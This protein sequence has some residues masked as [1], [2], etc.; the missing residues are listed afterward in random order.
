[1]VTAAPTRRYTIDDLA[2]LPDDGKRRELDDG[3]IVEWD[4]PDF[5]HGFFLAVLE[6]IIGLFVSEHRLGAMTGGDQMVRILQSRHSARGADVAF[7]RRGR[8]PTDR[9]AAATVGVPD[10][11]IELI[12]PSD[13]AA[14]VQRKV[15]DWLRT[16]VKLLWYVNPETG[17]TTVYHAGRL[18]YAGPDD[19]LTGEDVLPGFTMRMRDVLD[20]L[21]ELV[22]PE[23]DAVLGQQ[24]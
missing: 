1:M 18:R 11:V 22:G 3:Q 24:V 6:R 4:V 8:I 23:D 13:R 16:G 2:G 10:F 5:E 15:H 12:S 17:D 7:Y 20:E 14:D 19:A 21:A 9:R